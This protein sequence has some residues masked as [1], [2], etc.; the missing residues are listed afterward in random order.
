MGS[1]TEPLPARRFLGSLSLSVGGVAWFSVS[2]FWGNDFGAYSKPSMSDDGDGVGLG[3][4]DEGSCQPPSRREC[5][6][7]CAS[8]PGSRALYATDASNYRQ[9]PI[10]VVLPRDAED[11]VAAARGLPRARRARS[12]RAAAA[13]AWRARPCNVA[14]VIDF[15]KYMNRI[16]ELDPERRIARVEPGVVLRRPARRGR[17]PRASPSARTPPPTTA[18]RWAA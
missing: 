2:L 14:V 9:V 17:A 12:W 6:A 13:P 7:R 3:R 4:H 16:L 11:V 5:G 8:T 18:A 10:G 15:S 1:G